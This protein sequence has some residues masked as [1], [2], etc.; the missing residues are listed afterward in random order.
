MITKNKK[1]VLTI[2]VIISLLSF[3]FVFPIHS[4]NLTT[5]SGFDAD[6][7]SGSSG[8]TSSHDNDYDRDD[9]WDDYYNDF[10]DNYSYKNDGK[11]KN[12]EW[13]VP[14]WAKI[15]MRIIELIV[16]GAIVLL[17]VGIFKKSK[18]Q[19]NYY[20]NANSLFKDNKVSSILG[21]YDISKVKVLNALYDE[22][23]KYHSDY[24]NGKLDYN[25]PTG[26]KKYF[27]NI[28]KDD[29]FLG[30]K[31]VFTNY[32]Y[33][34]G[35]LY[36]VSDSKDNSLDIS[37]QIFLECK[38]KSIDNEDIEF[39][40]AGTKFIKFNIEAKFKN[41]KYE[42]IKVENVL[43]SS[44]FDGFLE[45]NLDPRKENETKS[46]S[47]D[48]DTKERDYSKILMKAGLTKEQ[49]IKE[50]YDIYVKVQEAWMNDTLFDVKDIISNSM[51]NQYNAQLS[52]LRIKKQQNIMDDFVYIDGYIYDAYTSK[53]DIV[54][55]V[56]LCVQCKD[57]LIS[58]V[59]NEVIRGNSKKI[60]TYR[61]CLTFSLGIN[62]LGKCP[63]CGNSIDKNGTATT[64]SYCGSV[65]TK[66]SNN[67][68][69][70]DKKMISQD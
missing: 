40:S 50:S 61:Y 6:W 7:D 53:N 51:Y 45:A 18:K 42:L 35:F 19:D 22:L 25:I 64:C 57:Y 37:A 38:Y 14:T 67:M 52:T 3:P 8:Y 1:I 17:C 16:L 43:S 23:V 47:E 48:K 60:N 41:N 65:I 12:V 5:D 59:N 10:S 30:K 28:S 32:K 69:L 24:S 46:S 2:I 4:K 63:S 26:I 58:K 11:T 54:I 15:I 20:N 29:A 39:L 27:D 49:V 13:Y 68:V 21:K 55:K 66:Y 70:T 33:R 34:D 44:K 9:S 31:T 56:M 62:P 36:S